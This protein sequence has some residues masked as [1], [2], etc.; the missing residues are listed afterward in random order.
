MRRFWAVLLAAAAL[1]GCRGGVSNKPPLHLVDD[2]DWQ[3]KYRPQA[4]SH[5]F[6]DRRAMRPLVA[7]TVAQGELEEDDVFYRGLQPG[8]TT[9]VAR[10]P[11]PVTKAQI[12]RGQERYNIYC[13]PCHDQAGY[14]RGLVVQRGYH[15]PTDLHSDRVR[16]LPDGEIFRAIG[17][18]VRNMPAYASQ[19]PT[20][21]RWAIVT[22]V[23]VLERSQRASIDEVPMELRAKIEPEAAK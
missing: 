19:I 4:E 12:L 16:T 21:D 15:I 17:N 8:T 22:W 7:G 20:A 10:S 3:P 13:A 1:A 9:P 2:M 11:L 18:G 14:G 5:F 6:A 23:R